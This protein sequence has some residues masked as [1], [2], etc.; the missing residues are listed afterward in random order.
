MHYRSNNIAGKALANLLQCMSPNLQRNARALA[1]TLALALVSLA[2]CANFDYGKDFDETQVRKLQV[3]SSTTV[4]AQ[5]VLGSPLKSEQRAD[6]NVVYTYSFDDNSVAATPGALL[7]VFGALANVDQLE[8]SVV[9]KNLTLVFFKDRLTFCLLT[10][11]QRSGR[12]SAATAPFGQSGAKSESVCAGASLRN[13]PS[14]LFV[15]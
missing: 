4:D 10:K 1:T 6:G 9:R 7:G 13:R 8:S 3:G 14:W 12:G 11:S 2:G 15:Y 5:N